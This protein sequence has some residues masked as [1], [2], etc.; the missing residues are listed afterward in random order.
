MNDHQSKTPHTSG[1]RARY[2][3]LPTLFGLFAI[4][5]AAPVAAQEQTAPPACT[6][7]EHG[8]F[9]FWLGTWEVKTEDGEVAGTNT[10]T[11]DHGGCVLRE[12]WAGLG[13][14]TGESFN[15]Y[16]PVRGTWHQ[17]FVDHR[18]RLLMLDGG[19]DP[20]GRMVLRGERPGK[21]GITV[22]DEIIWDPQ[23]DGTVLQVWS[24]STDAGTTW[25]ELF[26]G[27]Y[28]KQMGSGF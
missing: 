25:R 27:T 11:K 28:H 10:I 16:D 8:H 6:A 22:T 9:D 5:S 17:T 13:G 15:V 14:G 2:L 26:R 7:D 12:E 4:V 3:V 19:L 20:R 1:T 23:D 18:G 24:V 21:N